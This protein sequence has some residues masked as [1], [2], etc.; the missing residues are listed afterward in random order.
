MS[1]ELNLEMSRLDE[2][3]AGLMRNNESHCNGLIHLHNV[4]IF[5][6]L[7]YSTLDGCTVSDMIH[8]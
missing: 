5:T 4:P 1:N 6:H 2:G 7:W 8:P 3:G